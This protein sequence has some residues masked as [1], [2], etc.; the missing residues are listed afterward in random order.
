[1]SRHHVRSV[2]NKNKVEKRHRTSL[3][4][5]LRN[6][7]AKNRA[8]TE[9]TKVRRSVQAGNLDT[10]SEQIRVA[11]SALDKAAAKGIIHPNNAARRKSRLMKALAQASA[12]V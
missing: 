8:R 1:M 9:V 12:T 4:R 7:S 10:A 2:S 6:Q 5:N 11:M 3:E